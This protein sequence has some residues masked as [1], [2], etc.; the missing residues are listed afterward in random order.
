[1]KIV[2]A[3]TI[4]SHRLPAEWIAG[5]AWS[6]EL[7]KLSGVGAIRLVRVSFEPSARTA[8]HTHPQGQ[9][10]HILSGVC[11]LQLWGTEM[12]EIGAGDTVHIPA[13]VKHWHGATPAGVMVH[14]AMQ[15][16][17]GEK[18]IE[19]LEHV[20]DGRAGDT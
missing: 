7:M 8:W 1:M 6:D 2:A 12:V 11:R 10:L 13:G 9:I 19:W 3:R 5:I 14:L 4:V 16:S 17:D 20:S 15:P 18:D